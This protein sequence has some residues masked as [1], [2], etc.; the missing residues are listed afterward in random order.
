M[1]SPRAV[2]VSSKSCETVYRV[3][4]QLVRLWIITGGTP[5]L[6]FDDYGFIERFKLADPRWSDEHWNGARYDHQTPGNIQGPTFDVLPGGEATVV[7]F[8]ARNLPNKRIRERRHKA[9]SSYPA[10]ASPFFEDR[11][12]CRFR[13]TVRGGGPGRPSFPQVRVLTDCDP[14]V[15]DADQDWYRLAGFLVECR[16]KDL[17]KISEDEYWRLIQM[18]ERCAASAVPLDVS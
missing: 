14:F 5:A 4:D 6:A 3:G 16:T 12:G 15:E 13:I 10:M 8:V 11:D 1:P 9:L 18:M 17:E 2:Q 7:D